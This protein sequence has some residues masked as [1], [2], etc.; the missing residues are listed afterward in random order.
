MSSSE[1]SI[2]SIIEVLGVKSDLE[3]IVRERL[4][5]INNAA[6][7]PVALVKKLPAVLEN[8]KLSCDIPIPRAPPSDF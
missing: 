2:L 3:I 7:M 8:I 5:I 6:T 1:S 4:H